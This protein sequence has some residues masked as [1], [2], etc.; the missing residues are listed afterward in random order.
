MGFERRANYDE[1]GPI[2]L[3]SRHNYFPAI[4]DNQKLGNTNLKALCLL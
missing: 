4:K 1:L 3:V 2:G